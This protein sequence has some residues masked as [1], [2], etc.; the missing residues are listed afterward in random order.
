MNVFLTVLGLISGYLLGSVPFAL[1][2]GKRF[3]GM[4]VR[5]YGSGNL[6]GTNVIR[7][8]GPKIGIPVILCDIGKG[9]LAAGL[10]LLL[11]GELVGLFAGLLAVLGH[12]YPVFAGFRG[13]KGV[14]TG[15]GVFLFLAPGPVLIALSIFAIVL[16]LFGY[17]SLASII[18]SASAMVLLILPSFITG[19][20]VSGFTR[21][22]GVLAAAFIIYKHRSNINKLIVGEEKRTLYKN[23]KK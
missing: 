18:A 5:Q 3:G 12:L 23:W 1:I 13:G 4:D 8:L 16:L 22:G 6:G 7:L 19:M 20:E 10:G 11:G 14:A 9:A 2:F 21:F 17:V 15:A